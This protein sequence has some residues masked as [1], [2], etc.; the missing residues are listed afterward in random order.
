MTLVTVYHIYLAGDS[1]SKYCLACTSY[2]LRLE[3]FC[4]DSFQAVLRCVFVTAA[5]AVQNQI[6][7]I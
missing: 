5:E 3:I 6:E 7:L 2:K 1:V 4:A